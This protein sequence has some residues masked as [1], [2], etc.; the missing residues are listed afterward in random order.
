MMDEE[1]WFL[2]KATQNFFRQSMNAG[3]N[4]IK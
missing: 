1:V 2:G 3:A 4:P